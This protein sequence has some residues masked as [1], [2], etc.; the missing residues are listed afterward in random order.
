M[1]APLAGLEVVSRKATTSSRCSPTKATLARVGGRATYL[2]SSLLVVMKDVRREVLYR[3]E[4][5]EDNS[6]TMTK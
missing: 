3:L 6:E 5:P 4:V 1:E 2:T